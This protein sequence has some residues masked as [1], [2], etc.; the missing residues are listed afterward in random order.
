LSKV[1]RVM[2]ETSR[3]RIDKMCVLLDKQFESLFTI[4]DDMPVRG[5]TK[6]DIKELMIR[7]IETA[8]IESLAIARHKFKAFPND[9]RE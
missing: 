8:I 6:Q 7:S 3:L 2:N 9:V 5:M 4:I 1:L